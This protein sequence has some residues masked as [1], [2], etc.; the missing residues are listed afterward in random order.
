M[1]K[2]LVLCALPVFAAC[3]DF[4]AAYSA[5]TS[6]GGNC[7]AAVPAGD[8][9][10]DAGEDAGEQDAGVDAGGEGGGAVYGLLRTP[11]GGLFRLLC[12]DGGF[13]LEH[14]LGSLEPL[15][16]VWGNDAGEVWAVGS[17]GTVLRLDESGWSTIPGTPRN[18]IQDV[19]QDPDGT[20]H[21]VGNGVTGRRSSDGVM[22]WRADCPSCE[23]RRVWSDG[24][25]QAATGINSGLSEPSLLES[26][27]GGPYTAVPLTFD[28]GALFIDTITGTW[29]DLWVMGNMGGAHRTD[30]GW[31]HDDSIPR[32]SWTAAC[33]FKGQPA[34]V[35]LFGNVTRRPDDFDGG[36]AERWPVIK[37]L[38]DGQQ[39]SAMECL[40]SSLLIAEYGRQ[41]SCTSAL[42]AGSC[43]PPGMSAEGT[44]LDLHAVAEN[45]VLLSTTKGHVQ[46]ATTA[47]SLALLMPKNPRARVRSLR[48]NPV[49][50]VYWAVGNN[51][52]IL[53][54]EEG[55]WVEER[56]VSD[57][58]P[59]FTAIEFDPEGKGW[60]ARSDGRLSPLTA[61]QQFSA[62]NA[63][64]PVALDGGIVSS[65]ASVNALVYAGGRFYA[66]AS[67]ERILR[68]E[69]DGGWTTIFEGP[70]ASSY[71]T[72]WAAPDDGSVVFAGN[73][74]KV[75]GLPA[76][77]GPAIALTSPTTRTLETIFG[78]SATNFYVAGDGNTLLQTTNGLTLQAQQTN[79]NNNDPS[80]HI[81]A[82]AAEPSPNTYVLYT[83]GA[84]RSWIAHGQPGAWSQHER[85]SSVKMTS[86]YVDP[87]SV[88]VVGDNG[89]ILH[90]I[91]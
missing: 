30:A 11:D 62:A 60:I 50:G 27:D 23:L 14:P 82:I 84:D 37:F 70:T 7:V 58:E 10:E 48:K 46:R 26:V 88:F 90:L 85:V 19:T 91:R 67:S 32:R 89:G 3:I 59:D 63:V 6:P 65:S 36:A 20:V 53:R 47:G 83:D 73:G 13:C 33:H 75:T 61:G 81:R 49:T 31:Q 17:N 18:N 45:N 2:L 56:Y 54:R 86:L 22:T 8:G 55:R 34:A 16:G 38:A 28:G 77:G 52:L 40:S 43:S 71:L 41:R 80:T 76:D 35:S 21:F 39:S 44:I 24:V 12:S 66:A 74:G 1:K 42:D 9:G 72:A 68:S 87:Q 29:D 4:E 51:Q 69:A 15:S 64:T 25:R 57:A 5:C 78:T 79:I